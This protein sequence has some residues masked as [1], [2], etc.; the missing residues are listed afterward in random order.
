MKYPELTQQ[1]QMI[2]VSMIDEL[3]PEK[4]SGQVAR[5]IRQDHPNLQVPPVGQ[6]S[7][8]PELNHA[9]AAIPDTSAGIVEEL[10]QIRYILTGIAA[11][12]LLIFLAL[13]LRK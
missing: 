13:L 6:D 4:Y 7:Y 11:L 9:L 5:K 3:I 10:K 12:F 8:I 2:P 1:P